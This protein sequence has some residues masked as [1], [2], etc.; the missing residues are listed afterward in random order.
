MASPSRFTKVG[1]SGRTG[2]SEFDS[3]IQTFEFPVVAVASGAAQDTGIATPDTFLQVISA[4]LVVDTEET[5]G[6]TKTVD[7][8]TT[9]TA[10]GVINDAD[11]SVAGVVGTPVTAALVG[12]GNFTYTLG[13]ADFAELSAFCVV[14][15][16][17]SDA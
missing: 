2:E 11:V 14:T 8:G 17:C 1:V 5:T 15:A 16:L 13:S 12:G 4:V 10:A 3:Y 7:I 9:S 6:T